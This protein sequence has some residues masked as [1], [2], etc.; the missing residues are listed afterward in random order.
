MTSTLVS[1]K[2]VFKGRRVRLYVEEHRLP[3][4]KISLKEVVRF[5]E[6]V[7]ILPIIDYDNV[8]IL[9]QYRAPIRKWIYELPAGVVEEGENPIDTA[10]RELEEETGYRAK[11]L[12]KLFEMYLTPGYSTEKMHVF[13]A[14]QLEYVGA[15]PEDY[16]VIEVKKIPLNKVLTMI[17]NNEINDAKTI[18]TILYYAKYKAQLQYS[19]QL[20]FINK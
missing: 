16:E 14:T 7:V 13:L 18:A 3:N 10:R 12:K 6:S 11:Y 9:Y 20:N 5:P 15:K 1:E 19:Q 2:E 17:E 8:L 4:G